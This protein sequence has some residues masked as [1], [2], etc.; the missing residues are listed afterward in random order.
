MTV[1]G[2]GSVNSTIDENKRSYLGCEGNCSTNCRPTCK[3][4]KGEELVWLSVVRD[5]H[6]I[7]LGRDAVGVTQLKSPD[8]SLALEPVLRR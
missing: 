7:H 4:G 2:K 5:R 1:A 3:V 8:R 6:S